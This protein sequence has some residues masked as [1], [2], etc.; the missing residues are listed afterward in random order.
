MDQCSEHDIPPAVNGT[1]PPAGARSS[2]RTRGPGWPSAHPLAA[3]LDQPHS[4]TTWGG[5]SPL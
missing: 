5:R 1:S 4:V 2:C 3:Q